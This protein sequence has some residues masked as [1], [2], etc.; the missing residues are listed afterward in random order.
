MKSGWK[1]EKADWSHLRV[2]MWGVSQAVISLVS[3][4]SPPPAICSPTP[5]YLS[6]LGGR[7]HSCIHMSRV[8]QYDQVHSPNLHAINIV[9]NY[10]HIF[11][12]FINIILLSKSFTNVNAHWFSSHICLAQKD[13]FE[14]RG[15]VVAHWQ[16][17]S[18]VFP[19][20]RSSKC[21]CSS[22][23]TLSASTAGAT[24]EG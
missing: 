11:H 15:Q 24:I 6:L 19:C 12:W 21:F 17:F 23:K 18:S 4:T 14:Y 10:V 13:R 22:A 5:H 7:F 16:V 3:P 2:G 9:V 8:K 1:V 20:F